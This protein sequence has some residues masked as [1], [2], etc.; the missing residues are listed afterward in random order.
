MQEALNNAHRHADA[1]RVRVRLERDG[2]TLRLSVSD[3]GR[4]FDAS[5]VAGGGYG[6][7]SMTERAEIIGARLT[8][9]SAPG[10]GTRVV[11]EV[12]LV[13]AVS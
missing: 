5:A 1:T 8:V 3:N 12:P 13:E 2:A 7:R 4:G 9:H 10:D 11:V 6:L